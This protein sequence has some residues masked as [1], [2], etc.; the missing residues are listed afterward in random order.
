MSAEASETTIDPSPSEFREAAEASRGDVDVI[1]SSLLTCGGVQHASRGDTGTEVRGSPS[2]QGGR[3]FSWPFGGW[4]LS[5][6]SRLL[7]AAAKASRCLAVCAAMSARLWIC[8]SPEP[9]SE[10]TEG[11]R[12][13]LLPVSSM[14]GGSER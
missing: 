1:D 11:E 13:T 4:P 14:T 8:A 3:E 7:A 6:G 5:S 2:G 12:R 9:A 10:E